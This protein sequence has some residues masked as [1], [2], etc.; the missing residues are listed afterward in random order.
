MKLCYIALNGFVLD[1]QRFYFGFN[2]SEADE[3]LPVPGDLLRHGRWTM[4]WDRMGA[5]ML[6]ILEGRL[7]LEMNEFA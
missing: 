4:S 3:D 2:S 7:L 1:A 5:S 6:C